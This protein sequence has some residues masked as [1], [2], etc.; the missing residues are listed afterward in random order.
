[1]IIKYKLGNN[2]CLVHKNKIFSYYL[3]YKNNKYHFYEKILNKYHNR[4][5][6]ISTRLLGNKELEI[7]EIKIDN[8]KIFYKLN[9]TLLEN[10]D[11]DH[12]CLMSETTGDN[13]YY[14]FVVYKNGKPIDCFKGQKH[15]ITFLILYFD[16]KILSIPLKNKELLMN[17][18]NVD[19]ITKK[20]KDFKNIFTEKEIVFYKRY[21]KY[22]FYHYKKHKFEDIYVNFNL[23]TKSKDIKKAFVKNFNYYDNIIGDHFE[24]IVNKLDLKDNF[25]YFYQYFKYYFAL[26]IFLDYID[27][28]KI[29]NKNIILYSC[30]FL[31]EHIKD[32]LD[33][34]NNYIIS[35]YIILK[36]KMLL[37]I[38]E[39]L[40]EEDRKRFLK[41][42]DKIKNKKVKKAFGSLM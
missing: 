34:K 42:T 38:D 6:D 11:E 29:Q 27:E 28:H 12:Y 9:Q 13:N 8:Y 39:N 19:Y 4:T 26:L 22:V 21:L 36:E 18:Q 3:L 5:Y 32:F 23:M 37:F 35:P 2:Y 1:M 20:I 40:P 24:K 15:S 14:T 31:V 33:K 7:E 16:Y 30:V 10:K 41:I 17:W 25:I